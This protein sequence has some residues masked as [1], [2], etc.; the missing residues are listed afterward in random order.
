MFEGF[1]QRQITTSG[2]TINLVKGGDGPPLLLLH[3]YPQSH[4][5]WHK[6]APRLAADFT[7]IATDLRGYGDSGKPAG[8]P[9]H[10][11]YAKRAMAQDQA[12]VMQ[13]LG[14]ETFAVVS[15]DRGARV[16]HRLALDHP[17]RV[18]RLAV[19]DI[20]PTH[21]MFSIVNK[22]MATATHHWF[23]LIQPYD[24]PERLIGAS[25]DYFI[26][27]RFERAPEAF[28]PEVVAEYV[29]CFCAPSAIH[30]TCEDYR[31]GA[32]I[33]LVHDEADR[34]KRVTC[35]LFALW[36]ARGYVGRTQDVLHVW[37]E[38]ATHVHGQS[39]PCGHYLA[40]EMPEETYATLRPFLLEK[41]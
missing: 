35:P 3:G 41:A 4:V 34:G 18:I 14:Y 5:M 20:I 39:L 27:H 28:P 23:F 36:S 17:Q 2:T 40:E 6:I 8:D 25:A 29:R 37:R 26:R 33:D 15:H 21:R 31:A 13:Q 12:E 7:V 30:A 10:L 19:L 16:A 24:Y 22:E 32:S 38:Y 9:Q 1:E 11:T